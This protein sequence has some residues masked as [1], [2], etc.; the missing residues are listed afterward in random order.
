MITLKKFD[1]SNV[2]SDKIVVVIGRRA[3]GKSFLVRDMLYQN[4][5]IPA[6]TVITTNDKLFY[7]RVIPN[8]FIHDEFT[9]NLIENV[10][11]RQ[12]KIFKT[13]RADVVLHGKSLIDNKAFL[14]LDNCFYDS[15][16]IKDKNMKS[17]F[18]NNMQLGL[19]C[20]ITM[21]FGMSI[22]PN[23]RANIDY[24]FVLRESSP[25]NRRRIYE[26]YA[27]IFQSFEVFSQVMDQSTQNND[28][29]VIDNTSTLTEIE[30]VVFW[31]NASDHDDFKM[32]DRKYWD[33]ES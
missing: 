18:F 2:K 3:T 10:R 5:D 33:S 11:K 26:S 12:E 16:W 29:L 8:E 28:C 21:S 25:A 22:P 19:F 31:Y 27:Q 30:D 17:I 13:T 15:D 32:C 7:K 20:I 23:L 4:Q 24:I 6:G 1:I 14:V 9:P